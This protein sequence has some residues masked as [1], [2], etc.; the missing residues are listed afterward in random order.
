ME[1][2]Q[3]VDHSKGVT[4]LQPSQLA[5]SKLL[6]SSRI[7]DMDRGLDMTTTSRTT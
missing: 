4:K 3:N 6:D 5:N 7:V 1:I 2:A